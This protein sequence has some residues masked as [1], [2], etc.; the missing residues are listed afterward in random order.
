M[1]EFGATV[2]CGALK[3]IVS[4]EVALPNLFFFITGGKFKH[5]K[6]SENVNFEKTNNVISNLNPL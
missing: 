2:G 6:Y 5:H 4:K 3:E 1:F